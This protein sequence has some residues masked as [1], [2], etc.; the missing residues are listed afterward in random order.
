[1]RAFYFN[2]NFTHL[3]QVTVVKESIEMV[4]QEKDAEIRR[5]RA[6]LSVNEASEAEDD[7]GPLKEVPHATKLLNAPELGQGKSGARFG[8]SAENRISSSTSIK[9]V[10]MMIFMNA[11]GF[12]KILLIC[13]RFRVY[14]TA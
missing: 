1:M 7:L 2:S 6:L 8:I 12:T 11:F 10:A 3:L 13:L 9:K 5:L 14:S 4:I